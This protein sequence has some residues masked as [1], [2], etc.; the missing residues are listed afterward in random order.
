MATLTLPFAYQHAPARTTGQNVLWIEIS[1]SA[2][3]SAGDV[4]R[5]CQLPTGAVVDEFVF[6]PGAAFVTDTIHKM[7]TSATDACFLA[8]DTYST[9]VTEIRAV[10]GLGPTAGKISVSDA[11]TVRYEWVLW[12]PTSV[13]TAGAVGKVKIAYSMD[14]PTPP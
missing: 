3:T 9:G 7:G 13:I 6:Y 1:I 11:A 4:I 14:T 2:T 5:L 8:S 12:T 10:T